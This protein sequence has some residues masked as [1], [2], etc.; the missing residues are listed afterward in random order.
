MTVLGYRHGHVSGLLPDISGAAGHLARGLARRRPPRCCARG[1]RSAR[2]APS[3]S[4]NPLDEQMDPELHDRVLREGL[5]AADAA[6]DHGPRRDPVPARALPLAHAAARAC[7]RTSGWCCATPRWRRRSPPRVIVVLGELNVDVVAVHDGPLAHRQ[8]HA[9]ADHAAARRGG[10]EHRRVAGAA[11]RRVT[12][13]ARVGRRRAGDARA[14]RARRRRPARRARPRAAD[15]HVHRARRARRR[16]DDAARPGR[17]RRAL[18][19]RPARRPVRRG[20]RPARLRLLAA[21]R[22]ARG[23]PRWR[24]STGARGRD[25]DQRRSRLGGAAAPTTRPSWSAIAPIDLLLPNADESAV[26]GRR[27]LGVNELVVKLGAARRALERRRRHG[28]G[29]GGADRRRGRHHRRRRRLR[30]R[31][32]QRLAG[33]PERG[34][35]RAGARLAAQAVAQPGGRPA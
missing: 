12:L 14:E 18:G 23:A 1:T 32:P 6:G 26:L 9:V 15:R 29:D 11:R 30:R 2:P 17:Q 28:L 13:I 4:A 16:A 3:S 31:L 10:R 24:R 22:R 21:A 35:A 7:A 27:L 5:E 20:R 19:R 34:A 25:A 8:R 33:R